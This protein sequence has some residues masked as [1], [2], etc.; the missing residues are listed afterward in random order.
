[1]EKQKQNWGKK[2]NKKAS[3]QE[4]HWLYKLTAP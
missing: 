3:S 1:M 4:I 2:D